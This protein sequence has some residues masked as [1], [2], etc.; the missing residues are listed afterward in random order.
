[1]SS[2]RIGIIEIEI[3]NYTKMPNMA[4]QHEND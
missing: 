3:L 2:S 1:M 4:N